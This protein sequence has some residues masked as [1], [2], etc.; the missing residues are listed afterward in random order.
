MIKMYCERIG[1]L[2]DSHCHKIGDL[3]MLLLPCFYLLLLVVIT[4]V[5]ETA[6][7]CIALSNREL[8]DSGNPP[9]SQLA[10][11]VRAFQHTQLWLSIFKCC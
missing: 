3:F 4:V 10:G 2:I 5:L 8:L 7:L 9:D 6:S 11:T 1:F